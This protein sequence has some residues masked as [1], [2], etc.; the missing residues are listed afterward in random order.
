V[1]DFFDVRYST[2]PAIRRRQ[3]KVMAAAFGCGL[4]FDR[5]R[6]RLPA[7]QRVLVQFRPMRDKWGKYD[8]QTNT[9]TVNSETIEWDVQIATKAAVHELLHVCDFLGME[10]EDRKPIYTM[11]VGYEPTSSYNPHWR[12]NNWVECG[13]YPTDGSHDWFELDYRDSVGEAFAEIGQSA[14]LGGSRMPFNHDTEPERLKGLLVEL[15][16]LR[17]A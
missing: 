13:L 15:G 9:V 7:D 14:L 6:L 1:N 2:K 11:I 8:P 17:E 4:N 3:K 10:L 12:W 16:F 5:L